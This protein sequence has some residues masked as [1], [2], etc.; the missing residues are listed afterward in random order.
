MSATTWNRTHYDSLFRVVGRISKESRKYF[1]GYTIPTCDDE[2]FLISFHELVVEKELPYS[3]HDFSFAVG[4][5]GLGWRLTKQH[6]VEV[7][8]VI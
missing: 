6:L 7:V 1:P 5:D 2:T 4:L 8:E 3:M